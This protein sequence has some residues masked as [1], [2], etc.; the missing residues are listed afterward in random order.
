[1]RNRYFVCYDVSDQQRLT[2]TYKKMNG[3]GE[4][5]QYS[6]FV[7]DLNE[8]EIIFMRED[9]E[10]LLNM[11]EDRLIIINAG[12]AEKSKDRVTSIGKPIKPA[13]EGAIVI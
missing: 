6:V 7:C 9:L 2:Q 12:S 1:V 10:D 4:P 5:I 3:Y 11:S 13:R 8:R